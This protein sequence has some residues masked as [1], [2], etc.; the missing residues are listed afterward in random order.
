LT[1]PKIVF[2]DEPSG[3]MDLASERTLIGKLSEAFDKKKTLIVATHRFSM[4][5]L[6]DRLVVVDQGAVVADGPKA[7]VIEDLQKRANAT[8]G[9]PAH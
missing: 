1:R 3:A 8:T 2:L 9:Q 6:V 7:K 4:L 5:Q